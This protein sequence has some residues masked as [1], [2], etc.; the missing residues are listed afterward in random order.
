MEYLGS[1]RM[2]FHKIQYFIIF[3]KYFESFIKVWQNNWFISHQP[4]HFFLQRYISLKSVLKT[5]KIFK[6]LRHIS[7]SS[8]INLREF[9]ISL[10][11]L[12]IYYLF[13]IY[14]FIIYLLIVYLFIIY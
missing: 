13:I 4:M 11:R 7:I 5:L 2:D 12:F 8:E 9:V 1:H 3:R 10:L 6:T 14:L